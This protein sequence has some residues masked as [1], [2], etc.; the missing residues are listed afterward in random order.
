MAQSERGET[1]RAKAACGCRPSCGCAGSACSASSRRSASSIFGLGFDFPSASAWRFIALSAWLNV[2]LRIRYPGRTASARR[3]PRP[4]RL[5]HPAAGRAALSDRR[6]RES[7]HVPARRARHRL[8]GDA[9]A[10]QHDRA[11]VARLP[12]PRA[13]SCSS[14]MP[15]PWYRRWRLRAAACSTSSACWPLCSPACCSSRSMPGG[16]PRR[17]GR[18]RK[19]WPPPRWCSPAS[20]S[21]TRSTAS[22]PPPRTS[23][24]RRSRPSRVVTKE[25]EREMPPGS[26][27]AED[28]AL[29][30]SQA[31]ALPGD[32]AEADAQAEEPDPLHAR[33]SVDAA[34][35]GGGRALSR[36]QRARSSSAAAPSRQRRRRRRQRAAS[37]SAG[38]A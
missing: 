11:R 29:L 38:R 16:C 30:Q 3:S 27:L 10:P 21:C 5:R 9:A 2:F 20:R 18:C 13:C 22:P 8:G 28:I 1:K 17:R 15:L 6:H 31:D 25:L 26:P 14:I 34:D 33:L 23:S 4:A 19:R 32:P 24:A 35:R 7:V 12:R 37:A 36:L